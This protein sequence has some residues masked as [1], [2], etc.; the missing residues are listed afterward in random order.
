M[1]NLALFNDSRLRLNRR[2]NRIA[3][4]AGVA[5]AG[6]LLSACGAGSAQT[7]PNP[8]ATTPSGSVKSYLGPAPVSAD[9][10]AF[11]VNFWNNVSG[12]DRC[13]ACH[14]QG[15]QSPMFARSDDVNLAYQ[16]AQSYVDLAN[17]AS[18]RIVAKVGGGHHCWLAS[19]SACA[20]TMTTWIRNWAGVALGG[21]QAQV[22][23]VP[24]PMVDAGGA[25]SFPDSSQ[26]FASTVYPLLRQYCSRCHSPSAVSAQSPYFA[27]SDVDA[28]Y[29]AA[30]PKINLDTPTL[31]RFYVRLKSE[32]HNCWGGDCDAAAAQMLQAIQAFAGQVQVTKVDP[33][34]VLSR[35]LTLYDGVVDTGGSRVE[36]GLMAKFEFKTGTGTVAYDTSGV[37]PALNLAMAGDVAWVGGWGVQIQ[38][39]GKLQGTS[40]GSRKLHDLVMTSGE[41]SVEA[42][43]APAN[44]TQ[45]M[46]YIVSYSGGPTQRNMTLGQTMYNYDAFLRSTTT[47]ANGQPEFSTPSAQRALQATLQHVVMTYDPVNGRRIYV[48]GSL[49]ASGDPQRGGSL[50]QWDNTFAL[51]L[52]NEVSGDRPWSGVLRMVALYN[53]AMQPQDVKANFDAGVG[54]RYFLLFN[55]DKYTGQSQTYVMFEVSQ[56]DSYSYLFNK[57]V[58]LSLDPNTN[59]TGLTVKGLRIGLNGAEARVGQAYTSVNT[60]V[61]VH[62]FDPAS[63]ALVAVPLSA[64]GTTIALE[65]GP[66][67]DQFFLTFEQLGSATNVHTEAAAI[68]PIPA[69]FPRPADIGVR[70]F[71][72]INATLSAITRVPRTTP[73][74]AALFQSLQQAMPTT[75]ALQGFSASHQTAI[76]Q[77]AIQYCDAL[78][79]DTSLRGSYFPS[80]NFAAPTGSAF[81]AAGRNALI[82]PLIDQMLSA[83]SGAGTFLRTQPAVTATR[84]E[85]NSLIDRLSGSVSNDTVGTATVVKAS[86]AAVAGSAAML[87]E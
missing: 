6:L 31:S 75:G 3:L 58:F 52:G 70:T 76:A 19:S 13:G 41:Y 74:V 79:N 37:E 17:P 44:V 22:R 65:K 72:R 5:L 64:V 85:L 82:T 28:A 81:D 42:W 46:A 67:Y 48:N 53:K 59:V 25:R 8:Q 61:A 29:A 83:N 62:G 33:A 35:A 12:V 30:K 14:T 55:V 73:V 34:L 9:V 20:D 63:S 86:C 4:A 68:M 69:D 7:M 1:F 27:Q 80:F 57:P 16:A 84:S 47:G 36:T 38:N 23:L 56:Y 54:E 26:Q 39:K 21:S 2:I 43:V 71:E 60:S 77:L 32:F 40:A 49:V 66:A 78:V 15:N 87:I 51:V 10:Q 24:P 45:E 18:S 50:S 11:V